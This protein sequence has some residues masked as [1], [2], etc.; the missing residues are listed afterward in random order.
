[1]FSCHYWGVHLL[2]L[3]MPGILWYIDLI[4]LYNLLFSCTLSYTL[5][6]PCIFWHTPLHI[7]V[8]HHCYSGNPWYTKVSSGM[9]CMLWF[10]CLIFLYDLVFSC[11]LS[12]TL[13]RLVYPGT[14]LYVFL[15]TVTVTLVQP[16]Y[17]QVHSGM[18]CILWYIC[19]IFLYDSCTLLYTVRV[20]S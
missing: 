19:L 4:H 11:T 13:Y 1:M 12:F 15:Y 20:L 16:W 8:Y 14:R 2:Y 17:T 5:V 7:L 3:G 10:I 18:P 9:P 6:L